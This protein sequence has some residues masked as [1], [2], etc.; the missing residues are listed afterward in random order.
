MAD[1]TITILEPNATDRQPTIIIDSRGITLTYSRNGQAYS[2]T[3]KASD[4]APPFETDLNSIIGK[5]VTFFKPRMK[6][7]DGGDDSGF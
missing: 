6:R 4:L 5:L 7:T 2:A 1:K 3:G